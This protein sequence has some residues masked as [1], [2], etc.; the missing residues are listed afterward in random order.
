MKTT[1]TPVIGAFLVASV[2]L[3]AQPVI[4]SLDPVNGAGDVATTADF[5]ATFDQDIQA[6]TGFVTLYNAADDSVVE[7]YDV[8]SFDVDFYANELYIAPSGLTEGT[9]YYIQIDSTAV[10]D[11]SGAAFAGIADTTT[12]SFTVA[13]GGASGDGAIE[14]TG[15]G[16][17]AE[18]FDSFPASEDT[19]WIND[20]TLPAW[21]AASGNLGD[22][23]VNDGSSNSGSLFNYGATDATD[24]AL[25]SLGSGGTGTLVYGVQFEN[26]SGGTISVDSLAYTGE[27]WR[28][29]GSPTNINTLTVSYQVSPT[30]IIDPS[31]GTWTEVADANFSGPTKSGSSGAL[32]GN[33]AANRFEVS[34]NPEIL[35]PD[36]QFVM[37]RWAD[38]NDGGSDDGLAIDDLSISWV[39]NSTP[40]LT[41]SATPESFGEDAG[42]GA[43]T[44]TVSIPAALGSD[45][46]VDLASSDETE[47]TVPSSV[48]ILAGETSATFGIDAVDDY[49]ADDDRDVTISASSSGYVGTQVTVSVTDND[50]ADI[51]FTVDVTP[52]TVGEDAGSAAAIGTVSVPTAPAEDMVVDL[53]SYDEDELTVPGS[54]TILAGETS[55]SFDIDAV[56]DD[57][58]DGDAS[59]TIVAYNNGIYATGT[60]VVTVL[61]ENDSLPPSTLSAG[62]IAFTGFNADGTDVIAFVAIEDLPEG[63]SIVFTDNEWNGE[64]LGGAGAFNSG[65]GF[66]SWMPPAGGLAAGTVVTISGLS[67]STPVTNI[68]TV[69]DGSGSFNIGAS[70]DTVYAF[71][72]TESVVTAVL[73]VVSSN[74]DTTV[75]TGLDAS[76]IAQLTSGTDFGEYTGTR[77]TQTSFAGY[78]AFI[79]DVANWTIDTGGD[80]AGATFDTTMFTLGVGGDYSTWASMNGVTEGA[81]GDDDNDGIANLMEYGLGLDPQVADGAPGSYSGGVLSFTKGSDAVSYGDVSWTIEQSSDLEN[82]VV[83]TPDADDSSEIS[84]TLPT[85]ETKVFVRLVVEQ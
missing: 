40:V 35:V 28:Y 43:A 34:T 77:N 3:S 42:S 75:G 84:Y 1:I 44:G 55:A 13:G 51:A 68:G 17:Y 6:G 12:W 2:T 20:S 37:I 76:H 61:D 27:Q 64:T 56:G 66:A 31:A 24:R 49:L 11:T 50:L 10:E 65:E 81:T 9:S 19:P 69:V 46:T 73:A 83:V 71:Q 54:V 21:Y 72:G 74:S 63:E 4:T 25:G 39:D 22:L 70:G 62:S 82:W 36:G 26:T 15:A 67:T 60:F 23:K 47:A 59:V 14:M 38:P 57:L 8:E 52:S 80:Y 7:T 48:V 33:D 5:L 41:V 18:D 45:L 78:L 30:L 79:S 85:G 16:S 58:V 29:G 53:A 32:D